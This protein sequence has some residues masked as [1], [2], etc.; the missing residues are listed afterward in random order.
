MDQGWARFEAETRTGVACRHGGHTRNWARDI[1]IAAGSEPA[2][3]RRVPV[4][5]GTHLD[6]YSAAGLSEVPRHLTS[7]PQQLIGLEPRFGIWQLGAGHGAGVPP[8]SGPRPGLDGNRRDRR[9]S[10]QGMRFRLRHRGRRAVAGAGLELD[11]QP[12][13]S[14]TCG[15]HV[16]VAIGPAEGLGLETSAPWQAIVTPSRRSFRDSAALHDVWVI[17]DM[18]YTQDKM[19]AHK[20]RKRRSKSSRML[21][22]RRR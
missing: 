11:L 3:C 8:E 16:L 12:A 20:T 4:D 21:G 22:M 10:R 9:L 14:G 17:G 6:S 2:L 13:A 7:A 18:T 19:L 15:G 1:V 5:N